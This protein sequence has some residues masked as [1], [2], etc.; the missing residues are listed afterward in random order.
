M[1]SLERSCGDL[2]DIFRGSVSLSGN[3]VGSTATYVCVQGYELVGDEVRICQNTGEWSGIEPSCGKN[4]CLLPASIH[5]FFLLLARICEDLPDIFR[6]SVSLSGNSVGS[7]ATYV[8]VQGYELVGDE[9][10]I[11]Q[12]TGEWSGTEPSCGK[13]PFL[14]SLTSKSPLFHVLLRKKLW[15]SS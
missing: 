5:C 1:F 14:L 15:R 6:G 9:V 13:S 4:S 8:C 2:P 7:T 3:S 10:R 11:C 12:N